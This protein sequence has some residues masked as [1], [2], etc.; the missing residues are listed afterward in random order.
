MREEGGEE[1]G[2]GHLL[3][4][5]ETDGVLDLTN[6]FSVVCVDPEH[7]NFIMCINTQ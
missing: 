3:A 5:D 7:N 4:V 1:G 2:M 6:F